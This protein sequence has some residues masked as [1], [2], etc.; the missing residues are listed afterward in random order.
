VAVRYRPD[1]KQQLYLCICRLN[2]Q[3]PPIE[4]T[5]EALHLQHRA[6]LQ[7]LA[8]SNRLEASG[9]ARDDA[10]HLG[11]IFVLRAGSLEEA[12]R[13]IEQDPQ[14]GARQR[15]PEVIPW[16]RMWFED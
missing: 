9:P 12:R 14:V 4:M 8:D 3:A 7:G 6:W 2:P 16:Q 1:R 5:S 10:M 13:M 11:S 15:I